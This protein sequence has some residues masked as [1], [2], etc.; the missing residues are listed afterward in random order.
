MDTTTS[1]RVLLIEDDVAFANLVRAQL[2]KTLPKVVLDPALTLA[3]GL[4]KLKESAYDAVLLELNLPDSKG[5]KSLIRAFK[6]ATQAA[7]IVLS[8]EERPLFVQATLDAGADAYIFKSESK[9][10]IVETILKTVSARS[11][12]KEGKASKKDMFSAGENHILRLL[13]RGEKYEEIAAARCTTVSTVRKQCQSI[14]DKL[15]LETREQLI[16]WA[17]AH[18]YADIDE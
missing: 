13:A 4:N 11:A 16:A 7:I 1:I 10:K 18:G 14:L 9:E 8:G 2:S 17:V 5:P 3:R 12:R 6:E 15:Q